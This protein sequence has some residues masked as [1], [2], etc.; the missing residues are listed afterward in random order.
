MINLRQ[1][2]NNTIN[3]RFVRSLHIDFSLQNLYIF[4]IIIAVAAATYWWRD[5]RA[6]EIIRRDEEYA[7]SLRQSIAVLNRELIN[8]RL[9]NNSA[10][11]AVCGDMSGAPT[12]SI[13]NHIKTIINSGNI[14]ILPS[15]LAGNVSIFE[16]ELGLIQNYNPST[17]ADRVAR[18]TYNNSSYWDYNFS[19]SSDIL[20]TYRTGQFCKY[21]PS[22]ALIGRSGDGRVLSFAFDCNNKISVILA[23][24]S[25]NSIK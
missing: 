6:D 19:L 4:L 23:A 8:E 17:A 18:F 15:Y 10:N 24:T 25:E 3:S 9:I 14:S 22:T 5:K 11:Q 16:V 7:S 1:Q 21:F 2:I 12:D 20:T 13:R